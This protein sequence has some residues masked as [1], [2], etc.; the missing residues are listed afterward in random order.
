MAPKELDHKV[1]ESRKLYKE[2][3]E[4]DSLCNNPKKAVGGSKVYN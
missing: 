1:R 4:S 2:S 3:I